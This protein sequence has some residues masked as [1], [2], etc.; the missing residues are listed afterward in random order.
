[1]HFIATSWKSLAFRSMLCWKEKSARL[2]CNILVY[3]HWKKDEEIK[4]D[5]AF[6]IHYNMSQ[7]DTSGAKHMDPSDITL[8]L[9]LDKSDDCD[10][11]QVMFYGTK[12]LQSVV[13][14]RHNDNAD[15]S[16]HL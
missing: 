1:M 8:N 13:V 11:S 12:A 15:H 5:D 6:C 4:L 10:G 7:E 14:G 2:F 16:K 9:C 3:P